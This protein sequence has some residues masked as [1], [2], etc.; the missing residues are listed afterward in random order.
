M[1]NSPLLLP[2]A[3]LVAVVLLHSWPTAERASAQAPAAATKWEYTV[4]V[5][6]AKPEET[7]KALNQLA[8]EGWELDW[9]ISRVSGAQ[10]HAVTDP[11]WS[12]RTE[13]QLIL[14][15]SKR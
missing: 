10:P 11:L 3:L 15:R 14:K 12:V 2:I 5:A 8:A 1:K 7:A 4:I 9:I 6:A 13:I